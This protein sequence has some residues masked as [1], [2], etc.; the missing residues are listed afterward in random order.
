[1]ENA[2]RAPVAVCAYY[3]LDT[4]YGEAKAYA[5]LGFFPATVTNQPQRAGLI[6]ILLLNFFALLWQP[7]PVLVVTYIKR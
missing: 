5:E 6:R 4:F 2:E 3:D 1:M 7:A